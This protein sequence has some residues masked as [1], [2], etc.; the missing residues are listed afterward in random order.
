MLKSVEKNKILS[1]EV[2]T[3]ACCQCGH[4]VSVC[5][6]AALEMGEKGP[7][8]NSDNCIRCTQC[9]AVCPTGAIHAIKH[10]E[11]PADQPD[12]VPTKDYGDKKP[13]LPLEDLALHI[14]ARRSIRSFKPEAPSRE[15]LN[16]II[17]AARYAPTACNFRKVKYAVISD[18]EHVKTLREFCLKMVPMPRVCLPA[19]AV[20]LVINELPKDWHEDSV[21]AATTFD[22]VARS[23]G[24]GCTFAGLI[25]RCIEGSEEIRKYLRETCGIEGLEDHPFQALYL[26]YPED[27]SLFLRPAVREEAPV[28]W[29]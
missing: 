20:L 27:D 23:V 12:P 26:G 6:C 21:I 14:S 25:R 8:Y 28:V 10:P 19:P 16:S 13:F 1:I 2:D 5:G 18:P 7:I 3:D 17:Q 22:I 15:V 4:C 9:T 11:A 29:A 24:V